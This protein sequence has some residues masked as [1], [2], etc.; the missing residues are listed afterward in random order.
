MLGYQPPKPKPPRRFFKNYFGLKYQTN[1]DKF[2]D[3]KALLERT[4]PTAVDRA[5]IREA[6]ETKT[7]LKRHEAAL[8]KDK[9]MMGP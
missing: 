1:N 5:Q 8:L 2:L 4:N 6:F 9:M 7:M 3:G